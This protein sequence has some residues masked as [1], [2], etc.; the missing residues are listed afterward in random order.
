M[1]ETGVN[2]HVCTLAVGVT[3]NNAWD[4]HKTHGIARL[5]KYGSAT[6]R[7]TSFKDKRY[8]LNRTYQGRPTAVTVMC[9]WL[10]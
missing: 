7:G 9:F 6:I 5:Q 1:D 4:S 8:F 2:L 10:K 3:F